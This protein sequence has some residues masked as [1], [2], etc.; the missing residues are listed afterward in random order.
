MPSSVV[1]PTQPFVGS[2]FPPRRAIFLRSTSQDT[3]GTL[4]HRI[5]SH[6]PSLDEPVHHHDSRGG[7]GWVVA[8][9][10]SAGSRQYTLLTASSR[11]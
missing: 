3:L 1:L 4:I 7:G 11:S 8:V 9:R 10:Q 5:P 6:P 2:L